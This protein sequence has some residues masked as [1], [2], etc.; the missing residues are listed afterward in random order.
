[1]EAISN[2]I[3]VISSNYLDSTTSELA[4]YAT[5]SQRWQF[6]IEARTF[7]HIKLFSFDLPRFAAIFATPRRR[8]LLR[9]LDYDLELPT[10]SEADIGQFETAHDHSANVYAFIVAVK[11]LFL[12]LKQWEHDASPPENDNFGRLELI[13]RIHPPMDWGNRPAEIGFGI[14]FARTENRYLNLDFNGT[15]LPRV[16]RV[17]GFSLP[18]SVGHPLHPTAVIVLLGAMPRVSKAD[19]GLL[20]PKLRMVRVR[21]A[22]RLALAQGDGVDELSRTLRVLSQRSPLVDLHLSNFVISSE[23]FVDL[24][25]HQAGHDTANIWPN[26]QRFSIT[27]GLVA[28][29]GKCYYTWNPADVDIEPD[30]Q[31]LSSAGEHEIHM[32]IYDHDAEDNVFGIPDNE[33]V[34]NGESPTHE[35]RTRPDIEMFDP[36]ILSMSQAVLKM[37]AL[38]RLSFQIAMNMSDFTGLMLECIEAGENSIDPPD[39]KS[40]LDE[41]VNVRRWKA[42]V[43]DATEWDIPQEIDELWRQWVGEE[44]KVIVGRWPSF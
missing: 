32:G 33:D 16:Q 41:E 29:N 12:L 7:A 17:T 10:Y 5:I 20:E 13:L 40:E 37:P 21:K 2:E 24:R 1:M 35:W 42:W 9:R 3:L 36:L 43:G 30:Q 6:V 8:A 34:L 31:V 26:L 23:L 11:H 27:S 18:I 19:L 15:E 22:H 4:P 28:P 14:G 25:R 38:K 39:L 44:G